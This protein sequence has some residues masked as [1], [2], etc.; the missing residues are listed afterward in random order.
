LKLPFALRP[1]LRR[2]LRIR[3][4]KLSSTA[5]DRTEHAAFRAFVESTIDNEAYLHANPDVR[6]AGIKPVE[7]WLEHGLY[8][9]RTLSPRVVVQRGVMPTHWRLQ[10]VRR[11]IWRGEAIVI[12]GSL[13]VSLL[14]QIMN[15]A[16]HE[17][18]VLA[19]GAL[20][21]PHLRW[22]EA[23]DL[24]VRD[25]VNAS[26]LFDAIKE[27]PKVV[28]V[29]PMLRVGG[30]EKY[31][32]DLI[33]ALVAAGIGPG[34]VLVTDQ[35]ARESEG[36]QELAIL[37][38]LRELPILHWRDA[39]NGFGY[40]DPRVL[41]N[42]LNALRPKAVVVINS[43]LGLD[44]VTRY[45]RALSQ[46]AFLCC[47]YFSM[48][49]DALGAV[50]GTR[51]PRLTVPHAMALTDNE[52]MAETLKNLYDGIKGPGIAMLPGRIQPAPDSVF[53]ARLEARLR[54]I[55]AE[56]LP[57]IWAWVSRCEPSKG[58]AIL[59]ALAALRPSDRF[60]V[61]GPLHDTM[62]GLGLA[63]PNIVHRG[64]VADIALVDF[65]MHD[66]FIFTSLFEGMPNIVLEMSQHAIPMVLADVGGLRDTLDDSA[67]VF[68][69]HAAT[70]AATGAAF[71]EALDR[72][73][74]LTAY[75]VTSMART[76]QMQ[77]MARHAPEN[78]ARAAARLFGLS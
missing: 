74:S 53:S 56:K 5:E 28:L 18:A 31:G 16:K 24:S 48:G 72:V 13:P 51:F 45:G 63:L 54:R 58:T 52:P 22:H 1:L 70:T 68:I 71:A 36:W 30:A 26:S 21:L 41:A 4:E 49:I 73:A 40:G 33:E 25:G 14:Q 11:F 44:M 32:A 7:H 2:V 66:G 8:E 75:Q 76:A 46:G 64:V 59:G 29:I 37:A 42:F 39:C 35:T 20:A 3:R 10:T 6:A 47:T 61:L 62:Q 17:P 50:F 78:H 27:R 65:S 12:S 19:P 69:K 9:G 38:P 55:T 57:K 77:V 60:E 67:V 34:L 43:R 23:Q 15:Q